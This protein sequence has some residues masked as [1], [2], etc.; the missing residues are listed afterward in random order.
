MFAI[1]LSS[2]SRY[3][4]NF[5]LDQSVLA[6]HDSLL[7]YEISEDDH[8][9]TVTHARDHWWTLDFANAFVS[10][11]VNSRAELV[12]SHENSY[13]YISWVCSKNI[14]ADPKLL[15][16]VKQH[17]QIVDFLSRAWT[18]LA[19]PLLVSCIQMPILI[20]CFLQNTLVCVKNH[21]VILRN[22]YLLTSFNLLR[23]ELHDP[24]NTW[25]S[26]NKPI[27]EAY[28]GKTRCLDTSV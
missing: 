18:T 23:L 7:Y 1:S 6:I 4:A 20:R 17:L 16:I 24:I 14:S 26:I 28:L 8:P 27:W 22:F 13:S 2:C 5:K 3:N 25:A 21:C 11:G 10:P 19:Q 9:R 15:T 12:P